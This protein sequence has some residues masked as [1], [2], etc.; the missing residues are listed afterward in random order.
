[1][2][3]VDAPSDL[4]HIGVY[5]NQP[6]NN[7]NCQLYSSKNWLYEFAHRYHERRKKNSKSYSI[8]DYTEI[9]Y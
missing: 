8:L 2:L 4:N 1:M 9:C 6:I 5:Q 3:Q 7:P